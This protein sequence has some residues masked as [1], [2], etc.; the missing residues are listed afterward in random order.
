VEEG[1]PHPTELGESWGEAI[2]HLLC[3]LKMRLGVEV[4]ESGFNKEKNTR[5][6]IN[7]EAGKA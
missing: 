7:L 2:C 6:L 3:Y 4:E 1:E 5:T